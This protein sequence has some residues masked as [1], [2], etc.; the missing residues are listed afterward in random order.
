MNKWT[1]LSFVLLFMA[2]F[3]CFLGETYVVKGNIH[4]LWIPYIGAYAVKTGAS[5][6]HDLHSPFGLF[7]HMLNYFSLLLIEKIPSIFHLSDLVMLSSTLFSFVLIG[8]FILIKINIKGFSFISWFILPLLISMAFQLREMQI[9]LLNYKGVLWY[10][11]YNLHLLSLLFLQAVHIFSWIRHSTHLTSRVLLLFSFIQAVF[12]YITFHYKI[13][14][15]GASSLMAI[16]IFFSLSNKQKIFYTVNLMA[17]FFL[18]CLITILI[19]GY[20]Y[21]GYFN[22]IL[23]AVEANADGGF[24]IKDILYMLLF[25]LIFFIIQNH[26][27]KNKFF[28]NIFFAI[29][30]NFALYA[31]IFGIGTLKPFVSYWI[32]FFLYIIINIEKGKV[33]KMTYALLSYVFLSN[34]ASLIYIAQKKFHDK[35]DEK[36]RA[37]DLMSQEN[38]FLLENR[39]NMSNLHTRFYENF[40]ETENNFLKISYSKK[41]LV[42]D[43]AFFNREHHYTIKDAIHRIRGVSNNANNRVMMLELA[44]PL[45]L[46]LNSKMLSGTIHWIHFGRTVSPKKHKH[47]LYNV[48]LKSDFIYVPLISAGLISQSRLNCLFY[49]WNFMNDKFK[50]YSINRYGLLFV[51]NS[52]MNEYNLKPN[53]L[54]VEERHNILEEC[55]KS[56]ADE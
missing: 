32:V 31:G 3:G 8:L 45:P 37:V 13:N 29:F 27:E 35:K 39:I 7:Y 14:F 11:S 55:K 43:A 20:S 42:W 18:F 12:I 5:L 9:S 50:F 10:S 16:S 6:H 48:F 22:D 56:L 26:Y 36:Y 44:N 17:F 21:I 38:D 47:L 4:D 52:K 24:M 1:F 51:E 23:V 49:R 2:I 54:L 15:F 40:V 34:S 46:L 33:K 30:I 53:D 41:K 28:K 25:S 19:A